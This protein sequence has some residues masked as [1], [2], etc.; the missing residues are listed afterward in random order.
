MLAQ[1]GFQPGISFLDFKIGFTVSQRLLHMFAGPWN[2]PF[3][4]LCCQEI[5]NYCPKPLFQATFLSV[6]IG[7]RT[8]VLIQ[9]AIPPKQ[10]KTTQ[11]K[12]V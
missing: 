10:V 11:T 4:M 12:H 1:L 6:Q 3:A 9:T 7:Y 8:G 5:C 2:C